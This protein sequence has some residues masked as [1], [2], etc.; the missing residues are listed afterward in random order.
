[1]KSIK[2][3]R[4]YDGSK[5]KFG[6]LSVSA[7]GANADNVSSFAALRTSD[8]ALTLMLINKALTGTTPATVNLANYA[9]SGNAQRWQLASNAIT[10][11]A[12]VTRSGS[13]LLLT[14][15]PQSV[16]LLVI[17]GNGDVA[18]PSVAISPSYTF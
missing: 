5:S 10:H 9:A 18:P 7:S 11:E 13:S 8:K 2:M 6:D 16:T 14:L 3:Y 4:N 15:P 12:D 1:Y 17:P